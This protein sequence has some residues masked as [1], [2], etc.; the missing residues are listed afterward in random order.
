M[1]NERSYLIPFRFY[2]T[3]EELKPIISANSLSPILCF[4]S[5]YEELKRI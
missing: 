1:N 5:T 3:Y 4:Y 2:S